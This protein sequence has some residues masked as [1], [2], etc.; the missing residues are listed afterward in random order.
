MNL[1]LFIMKCI[2]KIRGGC[3]S[4][5]ELRESGVVIGDN[6]HVYGSIDSGHPF[7]VSIGNN[8]TLAGGS[9]ILTHD[10]STKKIVGYSRVGR[11]DIGDDVFIGAG[12][13]V[14]PN[15]RIGNKVVI[16]AGCIV[17]KDIPDNTVVVGNPARII[18]TYDA[19]A[20]KTQKQMETLPV[21][22]VPYSKKTKREKAEMKSTLLN[23]RYGFDD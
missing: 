21:W 3:P 6:C 8:V 19:Y 13:I 2:R 23:S 17:S 11:V 16:G 20:E 14:L 15:V 22:D 10:G 9:K 5:A 7:L 12:A 4:L 18:G 1:K